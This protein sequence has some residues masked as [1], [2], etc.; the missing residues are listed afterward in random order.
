MRRTTASG[1]TMGRK[2]VLA[3][4]VSVGL[5]AAGCSRS[6]R[7]E[8]SDADGS[9]TTGQA[10]SG[11]AVDFGTQKNVCQPGDAKGATAQGVTDDSI[12]VATVSD[13]GFAGRPGLNQELFDSGEVFVE[14]CNAAGGINGRKLILDK[15]D[16]ALT[17]Y[18]ARMVE[19]CREDFVMVGGGAVFDNTGVKDRLECMLPD[20][21]GFVVSPEARGADLLI[22]PVPNPP[23]F[24]SIGD[25][26]WLAE[27]FPDSTDH[28]G[29]LTGD[30]QTTVKVGSD[31]R[32]A[33]EKK[34]WRFVY[35]D[36]FPAIGVASWSPYV[37]ALKDRGVR[38]LVWVGEPEGLAKLEIELQNAG[39]ELDWIR[40]PPN[41]YDPSLIE[42]AGPALY[43]T[44]VW[45]GFVPF[46]EADSNQAIQQYLDVFEQFKPGAKTRAGLGVQS[47]SAWLLFA[48][49]ARDCGSELTRRCIWDKAQEVHEWTGGGLHAASDPGKKKG[50]GCYLVLEAT[51]DGF[52]RTKIDTNNGIY[53]CSPKNSY[54][55]KEGSDEGVRLSDVGKSL[56]DL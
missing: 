27:K 48:Q 33:L 37:Q 46:E 13:P 22:Q 25:Y 5:I 43:N 26:A 19:S 49:L 50:S 42:I 39:V 31:D 20:V 29:L 15:R 16:A 23:G 47:W 24:I 34:G 41:H 18:Q 51:P 28:I 32:E 14:W 45:S 21:A 30:I 35:S 12:R 40:T 54:F 38:G 9:T 56:D 36:V 17:N 53:N 52:K 2:R 1:G 11:G 44:Y 8:S 7:S 55:V 4:V 6:D 10:S 3:V